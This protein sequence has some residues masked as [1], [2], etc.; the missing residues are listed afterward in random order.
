MFGTYLD[1]SRDSTGGVPMGLQKAIVHQQETT[2]LLAQGAAFGPFLFLRS[3]SLT[4][5]R[6]GRIPRVPA[7]SARRVLI[8]SWGRADRGPS[9]I[10]RSVITESPSRRCEPSH[11]VE[12]ENYLIPPLYVTARPSER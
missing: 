4:E 12:I 5:G 3:R 7:L 11:R 6:V 9:S 8:R 1:R 2:N 10:T